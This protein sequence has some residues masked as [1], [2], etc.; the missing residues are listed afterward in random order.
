MVKFVGKYALLGFDSLDYWNQVVNERLLSN[1]IKKL[2]KDA[3]KAL[4]EKLLAES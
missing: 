4:A 2:D 1:E 3:K